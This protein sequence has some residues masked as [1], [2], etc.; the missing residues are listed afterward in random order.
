M[1]TILSEGERLVF[2]VVG[3]NGGGVLEVVDVELVGDGEVDIS[4]R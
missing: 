4:G 3:D 1:R 2:E